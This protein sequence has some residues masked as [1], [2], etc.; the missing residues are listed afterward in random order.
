MSIHRVT[1]VSVVPEVV[2]SDWSFFRTDKNEVHLAGFNETEQ[3]GRVSS[4]IVSF[5]RAL[6]MAQTRSGRAYFLVGGPGLG[7]DAEYVMN[8]WLAINDVKAWDDVTELVATYGLA[9]AL[10]D[11]G[12][13]CEP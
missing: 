3:E 4:R 10:Q 9:A 12:R 8:R 6:K 5:D 11:C 13:R 2:L 1:A 7:L